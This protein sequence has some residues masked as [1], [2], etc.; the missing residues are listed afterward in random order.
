M[1]GLGSGPAGGVLEEEKEA[2][3][4]A[5]H[6]TPPSLYEEF[7][8]SLRGELGGREE[9]EEGG[10]ENESLSENVSNG[11]EEEEEGEEGVMEE[12]G[13]ERATELPL[14]LRDMDPLLQQYLQ[15]LTIHPTQP[16]PSSLST[17]THLQAMAGMPPPLWLV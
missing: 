14:E 8:D 5:D 3:V 6:S 11:K 12:R 7:L 2:L 9:G 4:P 10:G 1:D 13:E 15:S 16:L 17:W